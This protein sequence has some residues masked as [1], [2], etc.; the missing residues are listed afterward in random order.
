MNVNGFD[1]PV[2]SNVEISPG[3]TIPMLDIPMMSDEKWHEMARENAVHNL[4]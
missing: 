2:I 3:T 1:F 4:S